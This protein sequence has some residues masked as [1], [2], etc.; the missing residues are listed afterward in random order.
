[1]A[2]IL[3]MTSPVNSQAVLMANVAAPLVA[4]STT[5]AQEKTVGQ[6]IEEEAA[7]MGVDGKLAAKVAFCESTWRQFDPETGKVLRGVHNPKDVG[8]FQI[9]EDY[10][11]DA[12]TKLGYNIYTSQGNIDYALYL[13]KR[14]GLKHWKWS[15]PCWSK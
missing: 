5:P 12:S 6:L 3:T 14:D 9:N 13:M 4:T 11:L 2:A 7:R 15:E 10:H 8:L 1:M